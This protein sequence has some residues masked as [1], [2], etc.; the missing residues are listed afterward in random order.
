MQLWKLTFFAKNILHDFANLPKVEYMSSYNV[1]QSGPSSTYLQW[2]SASFFFI[3][4]DMDVNCIYLVG[5]ARS[6]RFH[7]SP[8]TPGPSPA[9]A[10]LVA[11]AH[12]RALVICCWRP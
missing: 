1:Y 10:P 9:A 5:R 7:W 6:P 4:N 3:A 12:R 11:G 8:P 2:P